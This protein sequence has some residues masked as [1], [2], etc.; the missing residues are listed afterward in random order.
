MNKY[1]PW[2][3]KH[4]HT[5]KYGR[6]P[7]PLKKRSCV[8]GVKQTLWSICMHGIHALWGPCAFSKAVPCCPACAF[9]GEHLLKASVCFSIARVNHAGP[10]VFHGHFGYHAHALCP[11]CVK[12]VFLADRRS[13]CSSD[14]RSWI[15]VHTC[16]SY[17]CGHHG[18]RACMCFI[19]ICAVIM[20]GSH[21]HPHVLP[22]TPR[23]CMHA[24]I[25]MRMAC[26]SELR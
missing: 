11:A 1:G 24:W 2:P 17:M 16:V 13:I 18:S 10:N 5:G 26:T 23:P 15:M 22:A 4:G 8:Q 25:A 21:V 6:H 19:A 14:L 20:H 12:I 9:K 3:D 7:T